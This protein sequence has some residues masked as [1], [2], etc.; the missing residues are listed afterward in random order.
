MSIFFSFTLKKRADEKVLLRDGVTGIAYYYTGSG[1]AEIF[2][3]RP[4]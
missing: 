1:L 4:G 3:D 2:Q